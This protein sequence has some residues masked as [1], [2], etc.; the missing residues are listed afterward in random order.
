MTDN[1]PAPIPRRLVFRAL[2]DAL[3][4]QARHFAT[5]GERTARRRAGA[6]TSEAKA[7]GR[8]L[9]ADRLRQQADHVGRWVGDPARYQG[10]GLDAA[11]FGYLMALAYSHAEARPELDAE[12]RS[13]G[14]P[15]LQDLHNDDIVAIVERLCPRE[16]Q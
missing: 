15:D 5:L 12:V 2:S 9:R 8:G 10:P 13:L 3:G 11:V 4:G 14:L 6:V 7:F 1:N 16:P